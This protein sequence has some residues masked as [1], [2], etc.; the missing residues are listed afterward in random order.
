MES[1]RFEVD[2]KHK[3]RLKFNQPIER[4]G[5]YGIFHVYG[6]TTI[7]G[8]SNFTASAGLHSIIQTMNKRAEDE[9][10]IE[11]KMAEDGK[12][13]FT[14]DGKSMADLKKE[15]SNEDPIINSSILFGFVTYSP[16]ILCDLSLSQPW[17]SPSL[18]Q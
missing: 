2:K 18:A 16:D 15:N 1:I 4:E 14:V 12:Q 9:F 17:H 3:V 6:I 11:K 7:K 13:Y 8:D 10:T 5:E